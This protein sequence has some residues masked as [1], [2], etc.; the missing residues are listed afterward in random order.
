MLNRIHSLVAWLIVAI[1]MVH[2][3]ATFR[4]SGPAL[5][6][7]WFF[8]SGRAIALVGVV[9]VLCRAYDT[10]RLIFMP[11][12]YPCYPFN[13][14]FFSDFQEIGVSLAQKNRLERVEPSQ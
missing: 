6:K 3:L 10:T 7:L 8:G 4:L 12:P 2:M 14:W 1:G 9:N 11:E 5:G 13:P